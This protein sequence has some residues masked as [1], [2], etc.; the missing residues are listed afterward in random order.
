MNSGM[1][2]RACSTAHHETSTIALTLGKL[3][4]KLKPTCGHA[5]LSMPTCQ[6]D[7]NVSQA[8]HG[9]PHSSC[10]ASMAELSID[11]NVLCINPL[12]PPTTKKALL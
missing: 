3:Q 12:N 9:T 5:H 2:Q 4:F 10:S 7:T 1:K 8:A 6:V 11:D